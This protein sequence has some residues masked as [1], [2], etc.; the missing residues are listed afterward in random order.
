MI[1]KYKLVSSNDAKQLK[2]TGGGFEFVYPVPGYSPN[3]SIPSAIP[4]FMQ[5]P[6]FMVNTPNIVNSSS[7][8]IKIGLPV[9]ANSDSNNLKVSIP[10]IRN[11]ND[12]SVFYANSSESD[13]KTPKVLKPESNVQMKFRDP[14]PKQSIMMFQPNLPYLPNSRDYGIPAGMYPM[15]PIVIN[16]EES[17]ARLELSSPDSDDIITITGEYDKIKPISD[18]IQLM[19]KI[20]KLSDDFVV[21]DAA[22]T[23][24][25]GELNEIKTNVDA[26]YNIEHSAFAAAAAEQNNNED[27][28]EKATEEYKS[29]SKDESKKNAM[30]EAKKKYLESKKKADDLEKILIVS[31]KDQKI[32]NEYITKTKK[33]QDMCEKYKNIKKELDKLRIQAKISDLTDIYPVSELMKSDQARLKTVITNAG[34]TEEKDYDIKTTKQPK[35]SGF[36]LGYP[37]PFVGRFGPGVSYT[38]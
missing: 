6:P 11:S 36:V 22:F 5:L 32:K 1:K 7:N 4:P 25:I 13:S 38:Y 34:I 20:K 3:V 9:F 21:V 30:L 28:L 31:I 29:D 16:P 10:V 17:K 18:R 2:H 19:N 27:V 12:P 24:A 37:G 33:Y 35:R 14:A 26:S 15:Q 8:S 23:K